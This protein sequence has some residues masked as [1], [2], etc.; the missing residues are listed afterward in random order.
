VCHQWRT[1]VLHQ[2]TALAM[3]C[4]Q[5]AG[6][7]RHSRCSQRSSC[8]TSSLLLLLLLLLLPAW[9]RFT[10]AS[11]LCTL[12]LQTLQL[13]AAPD[14]PA[15]VIPGASPLH[16]WLLLPPACSAL[17]A[18]AAATSGISPTPAAAAAAVPVLLLYRPLPPPLLPSLLPISATDS[19]AAGCCLAFSE[20]CLLAFP[21]L[22]LLLPLLPLQLQ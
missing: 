18:D 13:L 7:S 4:W 1:F 16:L 11:Q 12:Q 5:L 3:S 15:A 10:A 21:D 9:H 14:A 6:C 8:C 20:D 22:L 19:A 2:R 17:P